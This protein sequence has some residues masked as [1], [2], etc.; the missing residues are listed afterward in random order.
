MIAQLLLFFFIL[1]S[2]VFGLLLLRQRRTIVERN[3]VIIST[4]RINNSILIDLDFK[5]VAQ[6]IADTIPMELE[7]GTGV[8][9]ILDQETKVIKRIAFSK[10]KEAEQATVALQQIAKPFNEINVSIDDPSNLMAKSLREKKPF[11]THKTFDVMTP[12]LNE[13][14]SQKIQD[15]MGIK[16]SF[17]YPIHIGSKP[18]GVFIA[19][20]KKQLSEITDYEREIINDFVNLAGLVIQN[21]SLYSSLEKITS[22]LQQANVKLKEL[23]KLKDDFVSI[24]SHELR[25]PMTAIRSYV[26]MALYKSDIPLSQKLQ[27]YLYRSMISTERLINMVND[28]LNI[29]R[30][31]SGRVEISPKPFDI[32]ALCKDVLAEVDIKAREKTLKMS[33]VEDPKLPKVF[34]DPDKVHQILLNLVGNALKFTSLGG[35][36]R[37]SFFS[38]GKVVDVAIQDNGAGLSTEEARKLFTKFGRMEGS[39]ERSVATGGTGLGLYICKSLITMMKGKIWATSAGVGKG[40]TFTFSLPVASAQVLSHANDFEFRPRGEAKGLEPVTI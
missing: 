34:A 1:L 12:I 21:S 18:I 25:T 29:S 24:A 40:A 19:S 32:I 16:T 31:E 28:M 39:Y 38:D 7:F 13:D 20:T 37:I 2:A 3:R 27:K 14:E 23:D 10:T 36:V 4:R 8:L 35:E 5:T 22:E 26:W 30:I 33:I 11:I 9:A 6:K 17:V 15:I